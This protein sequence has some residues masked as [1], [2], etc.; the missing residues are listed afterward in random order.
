MSHYTKAAVLSI[1][2]LTTSASA[3][4]A[5]SSSR[6]SA[7]P[8]RD[9]G[10]HSARRPQ[11]TRIFTA[12]EDAAQ[13]DEIVRLRTMAAKL[14]A[15]AFALEAEKA[16]ELALAAEKA[17]RKFDVD[18]DGEVSVADLK[19]G[20]EKILKTDLSDA[21]VETLMKEFDASGDGVLQLDEFVGVDQFRNRLEALAREEKRLATEAVKEAKREEAEASVL[22]ERLQLINDNPPSTGDKLVSV[23]PYL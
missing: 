20:L 8:A 6:I 12:A 21:R 5:P 4:V 13:D 23:L 19:A 15:E 18:Q 7:R 11:F 3:F 2:C 22:Q 9:F 1:L 14:R 16:E 17:F 10:M